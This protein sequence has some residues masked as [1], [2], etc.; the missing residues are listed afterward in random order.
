M[1]RHTWQVHYVRQPLAAQACATPPLLSLRSFERLHQGLYLGRDRLRSM[2]SDSDL[3]QLWTVPSLN[4]TQ[5]FDAPSGDGECPAAGT[6]PC[7][8]LWHAGAL[9]RAQCA[10]CSRISCPVTP[11]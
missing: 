6:W 4:V 5:I 2:P 8:C 11:W 3:H 7:C 1:R 10:G 9:P